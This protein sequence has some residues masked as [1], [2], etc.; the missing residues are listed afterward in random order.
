MLAKLN[1]YI[2]KIYLGFLRGI[3]TNGLGLI[4][5]STHMLNAKSRRI[6]IIDNHIMLTRKQIVPYR[7]IILVNLCIVLLGL[8]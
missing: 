6:F 1:F 7:F 2:I 4:S 8:G 3:L 5:I